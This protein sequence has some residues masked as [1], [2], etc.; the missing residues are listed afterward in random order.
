MFHAYL[1][2]TFLCFVH[3]LRYFYTFSGTNLLTRCHSASC[4]F[5]AVFGFR[6]ASKEIFLEL[7]GTKAEVPIFSDA[8]RSPKERR[9]GATRRPHLGPAWVHPRVHC[10]MVWAPQAS[11]GLAPSPI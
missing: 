8:T 5:S 9:S 1:V 11:T 3:T 10:P 2:S 6:K 4:L 7:D